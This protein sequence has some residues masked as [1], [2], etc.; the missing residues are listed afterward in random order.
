MTPAEWVI[1]VGIGV[2][3]VCKLLSGIIKGRK[4]LKEQKQAK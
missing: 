2:G 3:A 1:I 4:K